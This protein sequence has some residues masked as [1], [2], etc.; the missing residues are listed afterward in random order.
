MLHTLSENYF[1]GFKEVLSLES[2]CSKR[3]VG[4]LKVMSY[5]TLVIPIV[6]AAVSCSSSL[7][8]RV[9]IAKLDCNGQLSSRECQELLSRLENGEGGRFV[10]GKGCLSKKIL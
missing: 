6:V 1:N 2:T 4:A 9:A 5:C 7:K 10:S 3:S 8:G